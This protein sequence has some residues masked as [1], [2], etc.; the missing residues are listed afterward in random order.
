MAFLYSIPN[1]TSIADLFH[2][3]NTVTSYY[4]GAGI[5]LG[6]FVVMFLAMKNYETEKAYATSALSAAILCF[7]LMLPP[8]SLTSMA[9][10]MIASINA[11]V[12]LAVL[13][14]SRPSE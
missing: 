14:S 4:F 1:M 10:L 11:I 5:V 12:S 8:L 9:Q 3:A 6:F 7:L 2:F 13:Y